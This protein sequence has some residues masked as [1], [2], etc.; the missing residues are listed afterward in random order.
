M[1]QIFEMTLKHNIYVLLSGTSISEYYFLHR[2]LLNAELFST[3]AD[4]WFCFNGCKPE[5]GR[6]KNGLQ[7]SGSLKQF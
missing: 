7:P 1:V 2:R 5:L 4:F 6:E 3:S